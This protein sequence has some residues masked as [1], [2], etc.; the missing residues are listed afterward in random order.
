VRKRR[1]RGVDGEGVE[2]EKYGAGRDREILARLRMG[3]PGGIGA[4]LMDDEKQ[5]GCFIL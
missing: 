2:V 5:I 1:R 4:V 3:L